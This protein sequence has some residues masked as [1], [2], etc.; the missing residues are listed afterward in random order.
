MLV[1]LHRTC[2]MPR[3][4]QFRT[5]DYWQ[6]QRR[7]AH[8][9]DTP[10]SLIRLVTCSECRVSICPVYTKFPRPQSVSDPLP[11]PQSSKC[12]VPN[13]KEKTFIRTP[14]S[15]Q[16]YFNNALKMKFSL[17]LPV[18]QL[19]SIKNFLIEKLLFNFDWFHEEKRKEIVRN[20]EK[21][22]PYTHFR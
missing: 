19:Y 18:N 10:P 7:C 6:Q 4:L 11:Q 16:L 22:Q 15:F 12:S 21:T 5:R 3:P 8:S 14:S 9:I 1:P 20:V 2:T 13:K 17:Q